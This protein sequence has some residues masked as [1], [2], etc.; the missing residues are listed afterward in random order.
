M[1]KLNRERGLAERRLEK[2][3]RKAARKQAAAHER[4]A[5]TRA[6]AQEDADAQ[7]ETRE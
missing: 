2:Q 7:A 3:A 5:S 6:R 4:D 1:A